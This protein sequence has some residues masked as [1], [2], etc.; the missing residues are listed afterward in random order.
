MDDLNPTQMFN[1]AFDAYLTDLE[2]IAD[3]DL[4][5]CG[6][7]VCS[8]H[9]DAPHGFDRNGSH[10]AGRYVCKCEGWEPPFDNPLVK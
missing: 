5:G 10:N 9:P 4:E 1:I 8:T 2:N 7:G 6:A 3:E